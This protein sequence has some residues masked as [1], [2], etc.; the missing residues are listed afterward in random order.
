MH[1]LSKRAPTHIEA[2]VQ[3]GVP[4]PGVGS[5]VHGSASAA[6]RKAIV[7]LVFAGRR[8]PSRTAA[9]RADIGASARATLLRLPLPHRYDKAML[10]ESIP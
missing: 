7:A 10:S 3:T 9:K 1:Q 5:G 4:S 6:T 8:Q 2:M